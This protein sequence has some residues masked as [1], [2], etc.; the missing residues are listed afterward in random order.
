LAGYYT[1]IVPADRC[2]EQR[3]NGDGQ[4]FFEEADY[5]QYVDLF[6]HAARRGGCEVW[7]YCLM[8]N[9]VHA[10][11]MPSDEDGLRRTFGAQDRRY[12][13]YINARTRKTAHV[14]Q[15]RFG[16]VAMD[17]PYLRGALRYV[18]P[19]PVRARLM[20]RPEGWRWSSVRT[21]VAGQDDALVAAAPALERVPDFAAFLAER[22]DDAAAYLALR[23]AESIGRPV[24]DTAWIKALEARTGR[25]L[26]PAKRGRSRGVC[27]PTLLPEA[28]TSRSSAEGRRHDTGNQDRQPG[29]SVERECWP[30]HPRNSTS[31]PS[32]IALP[33]RPH[34]QSAQWS[35]R[36]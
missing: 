9:H 11:V 23:C 13:G 28:G 31:R 35:C 22:V 7:A 17:E 29:S 15:G 2:A 26:A 10:I 21:H 27:G 25:T 30:T 12:A 16:S 18:S 19:N 33:A 1:C 6:A 36:L 8:P 3:G 4:T 24:G 5:A 32:A 20:E 34:Q 14:W